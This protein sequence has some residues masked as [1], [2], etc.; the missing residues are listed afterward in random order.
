MYGALMKQKVY[1]LN[2]IK[3]VHSSIESWMEAWL[4]IVFKGVNCPYKHTKIK[5]FIG[6]P[7]PDG[8]R[9]EP[10]FEF[11]RGD[12]PSNLGMHWIRTQV[13]SSIVSSVIFSYCI[14]RDN[15]K[16]KERI[17]WLTVKAL[18]TMKRIIKN[19]RPMSNLEKL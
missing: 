15:S 13:R 3:T 8:Q 2:V 6:K 16:R 10:F 4:P 17:S 1:L 9:I 18:Q 12:I 11:C 19:W 14:K 5:N 7:E